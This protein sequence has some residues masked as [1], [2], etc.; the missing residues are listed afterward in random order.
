MMTDNSNCW[1]LQVQL[2]HCERISD[3]WWDLIVPLFC[4]PLSRQSTQWAK[5]WSISSPATRKLKYF[6][7]LTFS[8][9]KYSLWIDRVVRHTCTV[10]F[11]RLI[12]WLS[13][14]SIVWRVE[15]EKSERKQNWKLMLKFLLCLMSKWFR[16]GLFQQIRVPS[17]YRAL[18]S[19]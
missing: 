12:V 18:L 19:E 8:I 1:Q 2:V 16:F 4:W 13:M 5:L 11:C 17:E 10:V 15:K 6:W 9:P 14:D 3:S 7:S